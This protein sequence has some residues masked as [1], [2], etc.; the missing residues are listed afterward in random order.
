MKKLQ[1]LTL[2]LC[3][4]AQAQKNRIEL[5]L[6]ASLLGRQ[7]L[8]FSPFVHQSFSPIHVGLQWENQ[9]YQRL[10]LRANLH[11]SALLS[12]FRYLEEDHSKVAAQH[13]FTL[14]ELD[15]S[16]GWSILSKDKFSLVAGVTSQNHFQMMNYQYGRIGSFGYYLQLGVGPYLQAQLRPTSKTR[17]EIRASQP[18]FAW[19]SRSPYLVNDDEFIENI[20][21]HSS[22]RT[23]GAFIVDGDFVSALDFKDVKSELKWVRSLGKHLEGGLSY[24]FDY[25]HVENPRPLKSY[26]NGLFFHIAVK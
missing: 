16:K 11:S 9:N 20:S 25:L 10:G 5:E 22:L 21:S 8:I 17:F 12:R 3:F 18:A 13:F 6:G 14:V 23:L 1:L 24:R 26:Q 15:Y 19:I 2:L 7:D 4:Q